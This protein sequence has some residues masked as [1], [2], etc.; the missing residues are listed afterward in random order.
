V[1]GRHEHRE[2]R[3]ALR[4]AAGSGEV[5]D[6]R[7]VLVSGATGLVGG[8][9]TAGLVR[10]GNAVRVLTRSP[11]AAAR[12]L[13]AQVSPVVWD[14]RSL[15]GEAL[16]GSAAVVHLAGEPVFAGRLTPERRRRIRDSR[17]ESTR[18]LA[19]AIGA[20]PEAQRPRTL[21]CASAVG[22]YGDRGDELLAEEAPSGRGFLADVCRDWEAAAVL[23]EAHGTRVA[24]LR[25]G[26][27]LAR[28]GG[29]LP[30]M[31]LP[32]RFGAG[33]RLGDG[34]QWFPWIHIDDLVALTLAILDDDRICGPVNASAPEPVR[35]AELTRTLARVLHRPAPFPV[36][37]FAL[38]LALGELADELLGS[39]RVIPARALAH[40]FAFAHADLEAALAR[41]LRP[42]SGR[43]SQ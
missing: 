11:E 19:R 13:G 29:A 40:G 2:H 6:S 7:G 1:E 42:S 26:I 35:N 16:T 23:A 14:G 32:F 28:E 30:R 8:R 43:G 12:R 39:R 33:G 37:A 31:A 25:I 10:R 18:S 15:P 36:P 38:R 5:S 27:V 22:Y 3:R 17:I 21:V 41:E 24:R 9:L 4:T 20:L 34:R